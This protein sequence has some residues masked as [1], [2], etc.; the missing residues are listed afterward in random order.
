MVDYKKFFKDKKILMIQQRDWGITSGHPLAIQLNKLGAKISAYTFKLGTAW[1]IKNQTDF[2]YDKIVVDEEIKEHSKKIVAEN[3][4][5]PYKFEEIFGFSIWKYVSTLREYAYSFDKK[6]YYSY[7]QNLTDNEILDYLLAVSHSI[8]SLIDDFAPDVIFSQYYGDF[9]HIIFNEYGKKKNIKMLGLI[10][11][12]INGGHMFSYDYLNRDNKFIQQIQKS[13]HSYKESKNY[14]VA[15]EYLDKFKI[16]FAKQIPP[17]NELSYYGSTKSQLIT[18]IEIKTLLRRLLRY[19]KNFRHTK[20][21]TIFGRHDNP[22]LRFILRDFLVHIKNKYGVNRI[23]YEKIDKL[24]NFAYFPLQIQPES[25]IDAFTNIYDNQI[26]TIKLI[27]RNL[28]NGMTLV[29]KDHPVFYGRRSPSYLMKI[30]NIPNVKLV[31]HKENNFNL[32]NKMKVL[33]S[34]NGSVLWEAAY[35]K[36]PAIVLGDNRMAE[37]LP[38]VIKLNSINLIYETTKEVMSKNLNNADYD[39][40]ILNYLIST[41]DVNFPAKFTGFSRKSDKIL[42][43]Q[44]SKFIEEIYDALK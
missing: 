30:S 9:R 18:I 28:P 19:A 26:N 31:S 17:E 36:K 21:K 29:V 4:L 22:K 32:L 8:I 20:S 13:D 37:L 15:K 43:E 39:K 33:F 35:L 16:N 2:K 11:T 14:L 10:D 1:F 5:T 24:S 27:S 34:I 3:N 41:L 40:L 12:K 38:N 6:Y 7:Q 23:K 42:K 44:N 25:S